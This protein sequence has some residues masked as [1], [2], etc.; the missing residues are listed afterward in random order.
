M[1]LHPQFTKRK[2]RIRELLTQ[3]RGHPG[4]GV[5]VFRRVLPRLAVSGRVN[6]HAT[7][8]DDRLARVEQV[9]GNFIRA[10]VKSISYTHTS[11]E[12]KPDL[13]L[14]LAVEVIPKGRY[15]DAANPWRRIATHVAISSSISSIRVLDSA[16]WLMINL[17]W[18]LPIA[19]NSF[20]G[21][22]TESQ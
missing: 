13:R 10:V 21:K 7:I 16:T 8:S 1:T 15:A 4:S 5:K 9:G 22:D 12:M 6:A 17:G 2:N 14:R 18:P 11:S 3:E 20:E 19:K